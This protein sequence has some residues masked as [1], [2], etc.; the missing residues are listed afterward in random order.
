MSDSNLPPKN[1]IMNDEKALL[2]D[3]DYDGIQELDHPLPRW[4]VWGFVATIIFGVLYMGYY[5][6]GP[7]PG[8]RQELSTA[9]AEVDALK[10]PPPAA[11]AAGPSTEELMAS[12]KDATKL[13]H[14]S[15]VY[16]AKCLACHGDKGQ[17]L[18]GPNLTDDFW[19][20]GTGT[21]AD[22]AKV[23]TTGVPEK[24]MPPWGPVLTADELKDVV[25]FVHSLHG[26][27]PAGAKPPQGNQAEFKD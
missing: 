9:L 4:W 6:T 22:V 24:G 11:G 8:S 12:F 20:H 25:G 13:K 5:M 14:G 27:N 26:T 3:H 23:V 10:P 7:G 1:Q 21:L 19:I 16:T 17:G 18:I 15:E 2:L